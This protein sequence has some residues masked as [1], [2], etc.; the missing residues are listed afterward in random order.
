[1]E[2]NIPNLQKLGR[3]VHIYV[4][5]ELRQDFLNAVIAKGFAFKSDC[6]PEQYSCFVLRR[7]DKVMEAISETWGGMLAFQNSGDTVIDYGKWV[8]GDKDFYQVTHCP[9]TLSQRIET[10][11]EYAH[12]GHLYIYSYDAETGNQL[13]SDLEE[14][15]F[16]FGDGVKPTVRGYAELITV[17]DDMMICYPG[18]CGH[19]AFQ[20]GNAVSGKSII[21]LNYGAMLN[22]VKCLM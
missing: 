20:S 5:D 22:G 12:K 21:R 4:K 13:M 1:M 14:G 16:L 8:T 19:I 11:K 2:R 3:T 10:V 18:M 9:P 7:S 17:Q 15:G 6:P